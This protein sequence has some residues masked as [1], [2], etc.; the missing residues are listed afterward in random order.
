MKSRV[1]G[2]AEG[3]WLRKL[4]ERLLAEGVGSGHR[5]DD[6][7]PWIR[8]SVVDREEPLTAAV[9][10][11]LDLR[12]PARST[13]SRARRSSSSSTSRPSRRLIGYAGPA[14]G[15]DRKVDLPTWPGKVLG[16]LTREEIYGEWESS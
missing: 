3:R 7:A 8:G 15:R 11:P 14:A 6:L 13:C 16:R 1:C 10:Q 9:R 2:G 5:S 12:L 4:R